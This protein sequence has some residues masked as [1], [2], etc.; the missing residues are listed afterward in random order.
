MDQVR[1]QRLEVASCVRVD[2]AARERQNRAP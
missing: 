1:V 2:A